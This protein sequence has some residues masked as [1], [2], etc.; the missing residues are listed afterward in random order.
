M[1]YNIQVLPSHS[2]EAIIAAEEQSS[3]E[4][5]AFYERLDR[6]ESLPIVNLRIDVPVYRMENFRTRS[7]Q[8][9]YWHNNKL[10]DQFFMAGQENEEA[11]RIQHSFLWRLAQEERDSVASIVN[12]LRQ[13]LQREPLLITRSGVVV[14][15]NRRL[16]AMRELADSIPSFS[17]VRCMV[18]QGSVSKE[19]LQEIEVRLQMTPT[20]RLPYEWIDESLAIRELSESGKDVRRIAELMRK[21]ANDVETALNALGEAEAYLST[22]R[23]APTNYDEVQDGEQFFKDLATKVRRL[24]PDEKA[25]AQR[26]QWLLFDARDEISGRIYQYKEIAGN[27][28]G[29][30]VNRLI[31]DLGVTQEPSAMVDDIGFSIPEEE[32][33][34]PFMAIANFIDSSS[35]K[36]TLGSQVLDICTGLIEAKKGEKRGRAAL[37]LAQE[38]HSRLN[39][40]DLS[41]AEPATYAAMRAQL[42]AVKAKATQLL[43]QMAEEGLS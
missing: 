6:A 5:F 2:R 16:A 43:N 9:R 39:Q 1:P 35:D 12:V 28:L 10:T 40:I 14:N 7:E 25:A 23:T 36:E 29:T 38:A 27:L 19:E 21:R 13:N 18:L 20:T 3:T 11:Q 26:I 8:I 34:S 15:G 37:R 30:A 24:P 4:N 31:D 22:W 41:L 33:T 32:Q 17:H 42:E